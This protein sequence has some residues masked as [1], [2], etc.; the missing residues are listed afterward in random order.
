M[1]TKV[2][3]IA[4]KHAAQHQNGGSD[5]VDITGL[6]GS[7]TNGDSHDHSGGDG[8]TI[9][10]AGGGTGQTTA[11]EAIDAL[12]P[13]GNVGDVAQN[14]GGHVVMAAAPAGSNVFNSLMLTEQASNPDAVASSGV[15][16]TKEYAPVGAW[17]AGGNLGTA[18]MFLAG[19]GTQT[20]G[21][22]MG[23]YI[24]AVSNVTEEY[25]GAAW[26]AG[27]NLGTARER[28][29]GAG[30]QTA[31]LCMGGYIAAVSNVTEEYTKTAATTKLYLRSKDGTL[32]TCDLTPV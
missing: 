25:D 8:A 15:L 17:G 32:Y 9:P 1:G 13:P 19:C 2:V 31:G 4:G 20:A 14:V 30:T 26:G 21:L 11:Q 5:P 6:T 18:R 29:A 10:I 27:G 16:F 28:L 12:L 24:A 3:S 23:G 22:C 7:V